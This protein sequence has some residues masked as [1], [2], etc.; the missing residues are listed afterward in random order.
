LETIN[1]ALSETGEW[2]KD[3]DVTTNLAAVID[4]LEHIG[5]EE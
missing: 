5:L 1:Q 3:G 2:D 4:N